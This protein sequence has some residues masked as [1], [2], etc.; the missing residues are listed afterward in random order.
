[1]KARIYVTLRSGVL[2]PQGKTVCQSLQDLGYGE[3]EDVRIG[4]YLEVDVASHPENRAR[5][6]EMCR[7]VLAN[8]VIE[9][10]VID[11]DDSGNG[12]PA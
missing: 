12:E 7:R 2:D 4:R 6:E 9:D 5:L 3:V 8:P 10:F 11:W 1:M